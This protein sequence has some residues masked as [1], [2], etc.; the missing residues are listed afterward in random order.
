ME[1]LFTVLF[2]LDYALPASLHNPGPSAQG[3]NHT[4]WAGLSCISQ[5]S[6]NT[7]DLPT[8]QSDGGRPIGQTP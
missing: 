7:L 8:G 1:E 3:C 6:Q 2:S 4:Q 5:Q